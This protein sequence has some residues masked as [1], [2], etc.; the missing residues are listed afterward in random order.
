VDP[1]LLNESY[2]WFSKSIEGSRDITCSL[3]ELSDG[4]EVSCLSDLAKVSVEDVEDGIRVILRGS[5]LC[6]SMF[7]VMNE[8]V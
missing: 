7:L 5:S 2:Y 6:L 3:G 8:H 1:Q 4:Y